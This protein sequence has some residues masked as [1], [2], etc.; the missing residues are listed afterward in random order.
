MRRL[1]AV[2]LLLVTTAPLNAQLEVEEAVV[3]RSGA[4]LVAKATVYVKK[5][6]NFVGFLPRDIDKNSLQ[7]FA[8]CDAASITGLEWGSPKETQTYKE[9]EAKI[10]TLKVKLTR[11]SAKEDFYQR[12]IVSLAESYKYNKRLSYLAYEKKYEELLNKLLSV[13]QSISNVSGELKKFKKELEDLDEMEALFVWSDAEDQCELTLSFNI[14]KARWTPKYVLVR[15]KDKVILNFSASIKQDTGSDW[16][17]IS[18]SISSSMPKRVLY[19]PKVQPV[20]V[21]PKSYFVRAKASKMMVRSALSPEAEKPKLTRG[22]S[23][24]SFSLPMPVSIKSGVEQEFSIR[25]FEW[26]NVRVERVCIPTDSLAVYAKIEVPYP[27]VPLPDGEVKI[28]DSNSF[29]GIFS[30]GR[31]KEGKKLVVPLGK[32]PEIQVKRERVTFN[33]QTKWSGDKELLVGYK[34]TLVSTKDSPVEVLVK[35]PLPVSQDDR[36][37]VT[38]LKER[39]SPKPNEIN[40]KGIAKWKLTLEPN[41]EVTISY[42]FKVRYPANLQINL[43]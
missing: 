33:T 5:G 11:L 24:Y 6:R 4:T 16:K 20:Y 38:W 25:V 43:Y 36:I 13:E 42:Y 35:E 10:G 31:F 23:S 15:D 28:I 40:P 2:L 7:L 39:M 1:L 21:F 12:L 29:L 17:D 3:Y 14:S 41:K 9:L 32:D 22:V 37:K 26:S 19:L 34:I 18:L 27:S 30:M 8:N